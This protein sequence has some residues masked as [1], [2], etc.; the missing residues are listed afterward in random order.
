MGPVSVLLYRDGTSDV[1]LKIADNG[2]GFPRNTD[3]SGKTSLGI[4]LMKLFAEQLEGSIRF[5]SQ[6]GVEISL[7]FRQQFG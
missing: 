7:H 2:V 5:Q 4:Q 6:E 3:L 1:L